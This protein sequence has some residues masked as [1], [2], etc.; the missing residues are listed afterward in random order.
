MQGKT[1]LLT[2]SGRLL[3]IYLPPAWKGGALPAAYLQDGAMVGEMLEELAGFM[4]AAIAKGECRPFLLVGVHSSSRNTEYTPWPAPDAFSKGESY[5]GQAKE[6]LKLLEK[7]IKP[8]IDTLY[9]TLT[10]P[11]QTAL[12]GYSLGGLC[13]AYA[14]FSSSAFGCIASVCGSLWYPGWLDFVQRNRPAEELSALW[15]SLGKKEPRAAH[16]LL[17]GVGEAALQTHTLLSPFARRHT[18]VWHEGGHFTAAAQR[19]AQ[20]L[21]WIFQREESDEDFQRRRER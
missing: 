18:L 7:E 10:G 16:P 5:A 2:V 13:A 19:I 11:D 14:A 21:C 12:C 20:A 9:P 15:I 1:E 17:A 8:R 6:Y 3:S 4:E